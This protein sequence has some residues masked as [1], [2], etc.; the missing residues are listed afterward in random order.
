[1]KTLGEL[2][3]GD[4]FYLVYWNCG[5][6]ECV[7]K[8]VVEEITEIK[9]GRLIKYDKY[10]QGNGS[11]S[12]NAVSVDKAFY[13]MHSVKAG[14]QTDIYSDEGVVRSLLESDKKEFIK[15][16]DYLIEYL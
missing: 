16:I 9:Y 5:H 8:K 11:E 2:K 4:T 6:V 1:M 13:D 14:N 3:V 15:E 10:D 7:I 12:Y